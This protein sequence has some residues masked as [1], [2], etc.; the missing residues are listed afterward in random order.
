MARKTEWC[1][2][3]CPSE[4]DHTAI[5]SWFRRFLPEAWGAPLYAEIL[6]EIETD[7]EKAIRALYRLPDGRLKEARINF[8][9]RGRTYRMSDATPGILA[10]ESAKWALSKV[11]A[12]A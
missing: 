6:I 8:N 2:V 4:R 5:N 12:W 1:G 10:S 7:K 11:A 9:T 3:C